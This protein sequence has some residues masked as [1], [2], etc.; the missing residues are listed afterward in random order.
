MAANQKQEVELLIKAGTEGLKSIGQLVKELEALGEDT[1]EANEQLVGLADSLKGLRDQQK[2]VKQF[3]DLKGETRELAQEQ[4]KAKTQATELG[5]ALAQTEKPTKAQRTEFEKAR[6]AAKAADQ[7]WESNQVQLNQLRN[8]LSDAG[9]S[10]SNL[11]DEQ[12]RIKREIA[13]VD[14]EISNVTDELSQMRDSARSAAQGSRQLGDDVE[15]SGNRVGTF[16]DRVKGLGPVLGAVGS[17]LKTAAIAITGF[18]A[19]V[20]ASVATMTLFSRS[21]GEA[22]RAILNTSDAID[23]SAQKLQEFQA[24]GRE[25]NIEG[26]KISDVLKDVTEKIGDFSATGGGEAADVFEQLNLSIADFRSLS[27]DQQILKLS[28]AIT[29]LESRSE[30]V[31]FLES[32]ASDASLLLPLLDDNAAALRRISQEAQASGAILTDKELADLAEA[33]AIYNDIDLK[34]KGLVNRI[35]VQLAPVVAQSTDRVLALFNSS[36]A[37]DGLIN[38]FRRLTTAA[39]GFFESLVQNQ[40]SVGDGFQTLVDTVQFLSNGILAA[41]RTVQTAAGVA[42]TFV[43]ATLANFLTLASKVTEGLAAIGVVSEESFQKL[44]AKADAANETVNDLVDQTAEYGRQ[45]TKAAQDA[46][47]AFDNT[48]TKISQ[49]T[50]TLKEVAE[51]AEDAGDSVEASSGKV[52]DLANAYEELGIK[53]QAELTKAADEAEDA[54]ARISQSG[55]A[56]QKEIQEAFKVYA[57]AVVESGDKA[58]TRALSTVATTVELREA[59]REVKGESDGLGDQLAGEF[60]KASDSISKAGDETEKVKDKTKAAADEAGEAAEKFRTA[61]GGAFGAALSNARESVTALSNA[62]R[63]LFETRI[64]SNQFVQG[65]VDIEDALRKTN[66]EVYE[67]SQASQRLMSNSFAEWFNNIA[68][69]SARARQGFYEQRLQ[70]DGLIESVNAG[71]YSMEQLAR[72]SDQAAGR[73]D[74]LDSQQ[75][76]GL[77]SAIDSARSKLDS[78]SSSAESTLNSLRQRLADLQGDTEEAQRLQYEAERQ[79]LQEQLEQ[80]RQAGAD[81]A[82][83]DYSE[84]LRQLEKINQIE[85]RNRTEE[86]NAREREAAD[87]QRE[88][89]RAE[90]E[91]QHYDRAMSQPQQPVASAPASPVQ[92]VEIT[93]PTGNVSTLSGDP[94]SVNDLLEFLNQT[95]M[96]ATE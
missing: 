80:S 46:F 72:L 77:Q 14:D 26:D 71:S 5:K 73:F 55:E 47:N 59:L 49:T 60:D 19:T 30:Q 90:R 63:N 31:F 79:R 87:R 62:A 24:A 74:L 92:R 9:I 12:Q 10:T 96:R 78:L 37:A 83:D 33:N 1:G 95:G 13:G 53:S 64:G 69:Q 58:R 4:D 41:F 21:Q 82:A 94:E 11:S 57:A 93:L 40:A 35:G 56:T 29:Q 66:Q 15:A 68:L 17:G 32:L 23:I 45:A 50:Y 54:F 27:P 67:L 48:E 34:L 44:K 52:R 18:A 25:F 43:A 88:R 2:L 16:R 7:A 81:S 20:G 51:A 84:A 75:L 39:T 89:E 22:A 42:V 6:K 28:E 36:G 76:T 86:E 8:S 38:V 3:A 91:R 65:A 85:Q 61:W 70:L